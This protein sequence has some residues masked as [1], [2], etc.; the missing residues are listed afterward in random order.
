M[1]CCAFYY[2]I[3][4]KDGIFAPFYHCKDKGASHRASFTA[5]KTLMTM[6]KRNHKSKKR[7]YKLLL[8]VFLWFLLFSIIFIVIY[9]AMQEGNHERRVFV[10][11]ALDAPYQPYRPSMSDAGNGQVTPM[12]SI[13]RDL[14]VVQREI[15]QGSH[16]LYL[17]FDTFTHSPTLPDFKHFDLKDPK[18]AQWY[19]FAIYFFVLLI[20]VLPTLLTYLKRNKIWKRISSFRNTIEDKAEYETHWMKKFLDFIKANKKIIVI[21]V[22]MLAVLL[23]MV[24]LSIP[25]D[26]GYEYR[27]DPFFV[28]IC[29][30]SLAVAA[31]ALK[32]VIKGIGNIKV[33]GDTSLKG[34]NAFRDTLIWGAIG[35]WAL[36][37]ICYFIGMYSLGTQKS[38]LA[39]IVRPALE[40]GKMFVLSDNVKE[41]SFTLR[42]NGAFMGFYTLCK[43]AF[44]LI[45]SFALV[46]LAWSRINSF[47]SI[48]DRSRGPG[49]LYVFF[50]INDNV[51]ILAKDIVRHLEQKDDSDYTLVLVENRNTPVEG[52]GNGMSI[53]SLIGMFNFRKDAYAEARDIS[54]E[55]LLVISDSS[56][57]SNECSQQ[58]SDMA[59]R[60]LNGENVDQKERYGLFNYLGL[61]NLSKMIS[62]TK[63]CH[64]FF[65]DDNDRSNID[66]ADN[67]RKILNIVHGHKEDTNITIYC[68]ARNN[69]FSTL[70]QTPLHSMIPG[71]ENKV[72]RIKVKILDL[73]VMAAQSLF[74]KPENH[75][76]NFVDCDT[77]TATVTSRF[78]SMVIGFG[79]G[80]RDIVRYLY[81][82]GAF[83]DGKSKNGSEHVKRHEV[84]RSPF[85][86]T[87]LDK[88]INLIEPR[89][90]AKI[91]AVQKARN[92]HDDSDPL[93]RFEQ[94][95]LNSERFVT[96][97]DEKLENRDMNFVVISI[98]NDKTNMGALTFL[99]DKAMK[100]RKGNLGKLRIFVRNYDPNYE[101]TM[102]EQA[103]HFNELIGGKGCQVITIFGNRSELLTH[104]M[105]V[106]DRIEKAA[107]DFN[108]K[109]KFDNEQANW[110]TRHNEGRGI[111][112]LGNGQGPEYKGI[113]W[114][115]QHRVMRKETQDIHNGVHLDTKLRLIGIKRNASEVDEQ[116]LELVKRLSEAIEFTDNGRKV[117][118]PSSQLAGLNVELIYLNLA[119]NEHIRWNASLEMMGYE[120]TDPGTAAQC[121][122]A[123]K[124][125]PCLIGWDYLDKVTAYH[126]EMCPD[127]KLDYKVLDY[128]AVKASFALAHKQMKEQKEALEQARLEAE[129]LAQRKVQELAEKETKK[130]AESRKPWN[131]FKNWLKKAK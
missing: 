22:F 4:E 98:G 58:V 99:V 13:M 93:L 75:P 12:D 100:I 88:S 77:A 52:M 64:F 119:R 123:A 27:A 106:D 66:A 11:E 69:A 37:F 50:G 124:I 15:N 102:K 127:D 61:K 108:G 125:H 9:S 90:M 115:K 96:L 110:E 105:I 113:T 44:L 56:I 45:S 114:E 80:G 73:S 81:E 70:L 126:N 68:L 23:S 54:P 120:G 128:L 85:Q 34:K 83:M 29:F 48:W 97:I 101:T 78:E 116:Q 72:D 74:L 89:Y 28:F 122:E 53:S 67:L 112:D 26:K 41:I 10:P 46:S 47:W 118:F 14:Y 24:N 104:E 31:M 62:H 129:E 76:I 59:K 38:A 55:A 57:G 111:I 36:G 92:N 7:T 131:R 60:I 86:C 2:D 3:R 33:G 121:D 94:A 25:L 40:S 103:T 43:L 42:N 32:Y 1:I 117:L 21:I 8:D 65:L 35:V 39:S 91:P 71:K 109:N 5:I 87:I 51:K 49:D 30:A 20:V 84:V 17:F 16:Q 79:R 130:L 63:K 6:T 18:D 19:N 95:T 107:R 82:F